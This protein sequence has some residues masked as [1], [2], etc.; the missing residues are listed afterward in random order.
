[1]LHSN[2]INKFFS[3]Y[4]PRC[5]SAWAARAKSHRTGGKSH[6]RIWHWTGHPTQKG[7][8]PLCQV[9]LRPTSGCSSKAVP[10]CTCLKVPPATNQF[11]QVLHCQ[12]P[13]QPLQL[14]RKYI[15]E[16][17]QERKQRRLAQAE[18]TAAGK[19]VVPTRGPPVLQA[20]LTLSP[21][22]WRTRRLGC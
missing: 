19:G 16:A 18:K 10:C 7:P 13:T 12:A 6:L 9:A 14:A 22:W 20:G 11:A 3:M 15:P 4:P 1:M 2:T 5:M 17:K 8:R 21:P